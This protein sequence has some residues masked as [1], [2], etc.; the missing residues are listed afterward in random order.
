MVNLFTGGQH[1]VFYLKLSLHALT[2]K[3]MCFKENMEDG[4]RNDNNEWQNSIHKVQDKPLIL[5]LHFTHHLYLMSESIKRK[6]DQ[7]FTQGFAPSAHPIYT[8][9]FS[10]NPTQDSLVTAKC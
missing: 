3:P 8:S 9:P 2:A 1:S 5:K 10:A 6:R 4:Q 7:A